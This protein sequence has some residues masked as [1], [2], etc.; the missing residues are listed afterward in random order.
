MTSNFFDDYI[1][2]GGVTM[3]ALI[4]LSIYTLGL[5][6]QRSQ[7]LKQSKVLSDKIVSLSKTVN[8]K[9]SYQ[10]FKASLESDNSPLSRILLDYIALGEMGLPMHPKEDLSPID[11]EA[12]SLYQSLAPIST[13]YIIAPLLGVLG[14]TVGIMETFKQ[15]ALSGKRDMAALVTAI[16]QSLIT[17][18]WGLIIAVPAYFFY[19]ILQRK[20]FYFERKALPK[21]IENILL[22][23]QPYIDKKQ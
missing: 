6:I 3:F 8:S 2:N 22:V 17:T 14:T 12:E 1:L 9:A 20:I 23:I 4:P 19:S 7:E 5:I 18:M 13:S 21:L 16:D 11:D 15:F 10:Q